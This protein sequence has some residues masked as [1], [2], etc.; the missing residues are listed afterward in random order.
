M[1]HNSVF[2]ALEKGPDASVRL[3]K[4]ALPRQK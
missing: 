4:I 2:L 3:L 1:L